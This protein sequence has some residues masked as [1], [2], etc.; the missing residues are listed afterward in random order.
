MQ[1][2]GLA[3]ALS[4]VLATAGAA[5]A[6]EFSGTASAVAQ[7]TTYVQL[8][9]EEGRSG[10]GLAAVAGVVACR[11]AGPIEQAVLWFNDQLLFRRGLRGPDVSCLDDERTHV[12]ATAEGAPDPR[13][14][15]HARPTGE[16]FSFV[17]PNGQPWE[18]AEVEYY[19][20]H[21]ERAASLAAGAAGQ[22]VRLD[23]EG[24]VV[25][26]PFIAWVVE[27]G[28]AVVDPTL[29]AYYNFVN[30]V[31]LAK[32]PFVPAASVHHGDEG[33]TSQGYSHGA[34]DETAGHAHAVS[35]VHLWVGMPPEAVGR[36]GSV[37]PGAVVPPRA[38]APVDPGTA[39]LSA[40][41]S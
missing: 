7:H 36:T 14:A 32:L 24:T 41:L 23:L 40:G 38:I 5:M 20:V 2:V 17:D 37:Q 1:H 31:D 26:Q 35:P 18:V 9:L 30:V 28:P 25:W 21:V 15:A 12:W 4:L 34:S 6:A 39:E 16:R 11:P 27:I 8:V 19:T 13:L 10:P 29:A 3:G 33:R 22:R